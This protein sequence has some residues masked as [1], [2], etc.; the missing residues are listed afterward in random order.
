MKVSVRGVM[1]VETDDWDVRDWAFFTREL[2]HEY[3]RV[4]RALD[5]KEFK[6]MIPRYNEAERMGLL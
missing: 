5:I 3:D 1:K 4:V 6:E 2:A